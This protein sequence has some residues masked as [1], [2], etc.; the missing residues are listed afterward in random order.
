M[1]ARVWAINELGCYIIQLCSGITHGRVLNGKLYA[2][3]FLTLINL[4]LF[5]DCVMRIKHIHGVLKTLCTDYFMKI[6][7]PSS[8]QTQF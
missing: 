6:S 3:R 7:P 2:Q 1:C 5:A 8:E 4:H